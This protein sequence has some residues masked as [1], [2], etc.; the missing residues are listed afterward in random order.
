M[1]GSRT[2]YLFPSD[3]F[4]A[5]AAMVFTLTATEEDDV[6][7]NCTETG[8]TVQVD[9]A[10]ALEQLKETAWLKP[11]TG[12]TFRVYVA[13][14]PAVMLEVPDAALIAKSSPALEREMV[15]GL[16]ELLDVITSCPVLV[17]DALGSKY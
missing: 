12:A 6:P 8:D 1:P 14:W 11:P 4:P 17:P 15:C 3:W 2:P 9:K 7:S 16:P 5:T 13:V 10:G